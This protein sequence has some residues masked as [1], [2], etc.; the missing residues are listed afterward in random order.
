[1]K[2][3]VLLLVLGAVIPV[4]LHNVYAAPAAKASLKWPTIKPETP[5]NETGFNADYAAIQYLLRARGFYRGKVDGMYGNR[6]TAAV[7]AFQKARKLPVDGVVGPR[8]LPLLVIT[9]KRGSRG[10]AVR[11]AQI[12]VRNRPG[13]NG[14]TPNLG[15]EADG[16]FGKETEQ[17]V[18]IAQ[19]SFNLDADRL[20]VDGIMGPRSWALMLA[21]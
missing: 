10:D 20:K 1:M 21:N 19:E 12:L 2:K 15:L 18:R 13:I 16:V 5:K 3:W 17:A 11:A 7:K 9:V 6:T 4:Q 14:G 8:T